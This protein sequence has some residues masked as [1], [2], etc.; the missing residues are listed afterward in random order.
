MGDEL[1]S[2]IRSTRETQPATA[3]LA[4]VSALLNDFSTSLSSSSSSSFSSASRTLAAAA[5]RPILH[6]GLHPLHPSS[7]SASLSLSPPQPTAMPEQYKA[8]QYVDVLDPLTDEWYQGRITRLSTQGIHIHYVSW[9]DSSDTIIPPS[10]SY[11]KKHL[12][13][14]RTRS[15]QWSDENDSACSK[16]GQGGDLLCCDCAGCVK[17]WHLECVKLRSV[18]KRRWRC[19]HCTNKKRGGR[20]QS[21]DGRMEAKEEPTSTLKSVKRTVRKTTAR[22]TS[23]LRRPSLHKEEEEQAAVGQRA[24]RAGHRSQWD[25]PLKD[26]VDDDGWQVESKEEK[27][28]DSSE[29]R[30]P[31]QRLGV[32]WSLRPLRQKRREGDEPAVVKFEDDDEEEMRQLEMKYRSD[33]EADEDYQLEDTPVEEESEEEAE[34]AE[35]EAAVEEQD[36]LLPDGDDDYDES[37]PLVY[38]RYR[39]PADSH[40]DEDD[41][42]KRIGYGKQNRGK[43]TKEESRKRK[44]EAEER[45]AKKKKVRLERGGWSA[46]ELPVDDEEVRE[47]LQEWMA[48]GRK[49]AVRTRSNSD[50]RYQQD[51]ERLAEEG[52]TAEERAERE[53]DTAVKIEQR[54]QRQKQEEERMRHERMWNSNAIYAVLQQLDTLTLLQLVA[55]TMERMGSDPRIQALATAA[56]SLEP[57]LS[58]VTPASIAE[59]YASAPPT[60][61]PTFPPPRPTFSAFLNSLHA[62][63]VAS[64]THHSAELHTYRFFVL[65]SLDL[66]WRQ[67]IRQHTETINTLW[68][69]MEARERPEYQIKSEMEAEERLCEQWRKQFSH[70]WEVAQRVHDRL[71]AEERELREWSEW[72]EARQKEAEED[73]DAVDDEEKEVEMSEAEATA[74]L[75]ARR[76]KSGMLIVALCMCLT[77]KWRAMGPEKDIRK[78]FD[79]I[80]AHT[81]PPRPA[82]PP[83]ATHPT[84]QPSTA[85]MPSHD[86]DLSHPLSPYIVPYSDDGDTGDDGYINLDHTIV[87]SNDTSPQHTQ[88]RDEAADEADV[89]VVEDTSE[90][91]YDE[92]GMR[93]DDHANDGRFSP[94]DEQHDH[95]MEDREEMSAD[96]ASLDKL[97][98]VGDDAANAAVEIEAALEDVLQSAA[99]SQRRSATPESRTASPGEANTASNL[100]SQPTSSSSREAKAD[101]FLPFL[102]LPVLTA[103][104]FESHTLT[105]FPNASN[106]QLPLLPIAVVWTDG[107]AAG[108]DADKAS[109]ATPAAEAAAERDTVL[110]AAAAEDTTEPCD[111]SATP[112]LAAVAEDEPQPCRHTLRLC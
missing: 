54:K 97:S 50:W 2:S 107:T 20:R 87:L 13:P 47:E 72:C 68:L 31:H 67:Y 57:L 89:I 11:Q 5:P 110:S 43:K 98:P 74:K 101:F 77:M 29:R 21:W 15:Q 39:R 104:G 81:V 22:K 35:G 79:A 109:D 18:P 24:Q 42:K 59:A 100:S 7:S 1:D 23:Q 102:S 85:A 91:E 70:H 44:R 52:E 25:D 86:D 96:E 93:D 111:A 16:C 26:E 92:A 27:A 12:A 14:H 62:L 3:A 108:T 17:V 41:D 71:E 69:Q 28:D 37:E 112:P 45:A 8:G 60:S 34:E 64:V 66:Q 105:D 76:D 48:S 65:R 83:P 19:P 36:E 46:P 4:A 75:E 103:D 61:P 82:S 106:E 55:T 63:V 84:T 95:E 58:T 40:D 30:E 33:D 94:L 90:Q 78:A 88:A 6:N 99:Q 53:H 9:P 56:P 51:D 73:E 10:H 80:L 32:K 49:R 38:R